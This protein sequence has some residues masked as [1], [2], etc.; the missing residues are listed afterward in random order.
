MPLC[1]R[2]FSSNKKGGTEELGKKERKILRKIL[3]P[4]K[5][6]RECRKRNN[7]ELYPETERLSDTIRKRRIAFYGHLVRMNPEK[8]TKR[9]F[10]YVDKNSKT[11]IWWF[12][13]VKQD[14]AEMNLMKEEILNRVT[15]EKGLR[16][17]GASWNKNVW[18]EE[19]KREHSERMKRYWK[20]RNA[21]KVGKS[22]RSY[23]M[24][25]IVGQSQYEKKKHGQW[26]WSDFTLTKNT[27]L[28]IYKKCL[29][30]NLHSHCKM[31][32]KRYFPQ[33]LVITHCCTTTVNNWPI[34]VSC[35]HLFTK[36]YIFDQLLPICIWMIFLYILLLF[37]FL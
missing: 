5:Y 19:R 29:L 20:D 17:P 31:I 6:G 2:I 15:L 9:I 37:S 3:G 14:L 32:T 11:Q 16:S 35:K 27:A 8:L 7:K 36:I 22:W 1:G 23:F 4:K 24:W 18:T 34:V 26:N 10:D 12:I 28:Q 33:Q 30:Y 13:E 25:S 21:R